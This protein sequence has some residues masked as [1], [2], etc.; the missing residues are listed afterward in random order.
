MRQYLDVKARYPDAIVFFRLGDFYEMFFEDAVYVAGALNLTLTTRDKG[1]EDPVPMCGLPHHAARGYL[2][3]LTD[4]G[5]RIAICEQL[6]DPRAVRGIVRRDVVR[7]VTPGVILDEESLDPRAPNH[8]AAVIGEPRSGYGLA[9]LDVSTGSFRATEAPSVESLLDELAR[10]EPREVVLRQRD[11]D[12]AAAI[13]RGYPRLLQTLVLDAAFTATGGAASAAHAS[14][15]GA[16]SGSS[17][18]SASAGD[19]DARAPSEVLGQAWDP[20][21][22]ERA[23]LAVAAATAVLLYARATQPAAS[24][25]LAPLEVFRRSDTLIIDEQARAHLELCETLLERKRQGSLI[26]IID[27]TRSGMGGRLLRRWLL[28]P[29]VEVARI[30]RRQDAVQRLVNAHAARDLARRVLGG[31]GDL[32][33]LVGRARLGVATPR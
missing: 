25:P 9:F 15:D 24:L 33:R 16:T 23:P 28:L 21:L 3:K 8:V 5:H 31:I 26:D 19:R 1:K 6:E 32:E 10:A 14:A 27:Q 7:V 17:A 18:R 29:L 12:L 4:L 30:R 13:R 2:T 20:A 22:A 11:T